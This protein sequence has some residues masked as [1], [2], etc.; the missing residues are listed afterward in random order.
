MP[1][2]ILNAEGDLST[3]S[4]VYFEQDQV[5][6]GKE[7]VKA[8]VYEP[9]SV[10]QHVKREMGKP[11][12]DKPIRGTRLPPEVVQAAILRKL[13]QDA[14]NRLGNVQDAVI[15]VPAF[16]NEPRR[17]ATMDAG[18]LA[19]LKV[20]DIINEPTAAAIAYGV[21]AG[22]VSASGEAK[23]AEKILVY[24][25]GGGTFDVTL[26]LLE[27]C[28]YTAVATDG[29][30]Q[31]GGIDWDRRIVDFVAE[32]YLEQ[33]GTDPRQDPVSFQMLLQEAEDAKRALSNRTSVTVRFAHQSKRVQVALTREE[34]EALTSDLLQRTMFTVERLLRTAR[35]RFDDLTRLLL[36]GGSTRMPMVQQILEQASGK[37]VDRSLSPD[38]AVAHG[39][40]LY[41]GFLQR[42]SRAADRSLVVKNVNS[43]DLGV[44]GIEKAT[45]MKRRRIMIPR[46]TKLPARS[47][48]SFVTR[49]ANQ[50][51]VAVHVVEGGDDSGKN[52][53]PIGK[54]LVS[55]LPAKLPAKTQVVVQFYY[56]ANG[57][58]SVKASLPDMG[59]ESSVTVERA[60][61]M[62]EQT[63]QQWEQRMA[64]G[65]SL[66]G[67]TPAL[68]AGPPPFALASPAGPA[69][70]GDNADFEGPHVF[71]EE[72][73][74]SEVF[75]D[76]EF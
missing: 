56:A 51:S 76:L 62:T 70:S 18:R 60:S 42:G 20:L 68:A 41:A 48:S 9:E 39:A 72:E 73:Q 74:D 17:K 28:Q 3:P 57:R 11:F 52:A 66:L 23:Q 44:L 59:I 58:L 32:H 63:L 26:M 22:F 25:L 21:Q 55:D 71:E 34:F 35:L 50:R 67:A 31:L 15:T 33:H 61:G 37:S 29:D 49:R 38:E 36:V 10:L 30:V 69:T 53:T 1:Q 5:V 47:K 45:G 75:S 24:D 16:F 13:R 46:N 54:C 19:G 6:V 12:C 27:G 40:A 8:A 7:A 4:A 64:S 43:H 65:Q 14:E 2:T